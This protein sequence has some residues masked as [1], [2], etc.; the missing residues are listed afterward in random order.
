MVILGLTS[1]DR[2]HGFMSKPLKVDSDI[3]AGKATDVQ[4]TSDTAG[5]FTIIC[6]HYWGTGHGKI[7]M[8]VLVVE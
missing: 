1:T 2:A 5:D 4:V 7:K 6:D 8:K 3:A